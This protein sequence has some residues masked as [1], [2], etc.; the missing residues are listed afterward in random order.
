M[1]IIKNTNKRAD[2]LDCA[3]YCL[4]KIRETTGHWPKKTQMSLKARDWVQFLA[5]SNFTHQ[6]PAFR[7]DN[8]KNYIGI[9][10]NVGES[11]IVVWFEHLYWE[12]TPKIFL[13][14]STYRDGEYVYESGNPEDFLWIEI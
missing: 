11:G 1:K 14:Y 4:C 9:N 6:V 8:Q 2:G 13:E 10:P 3:G 12:G 5:N 7:L